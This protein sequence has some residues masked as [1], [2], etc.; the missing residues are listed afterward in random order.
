MTITEPPLTII[1]KFNRGEVDK[2]VL[3]RDDVEQINNSAGLVENWLPLRLGGMTL[4]PGIEDLEALGGDGILIPFVFAIDDTA[5]IEVT[6]NTLRFWINDAPIERS[7]VTASVPAFGGSWTDSSGSGSSVTVASSA[8]LRGA[9]TTEAI[10]RTSVTINETGTEHGLRIVVGRGP[11][12]VQ[13]GD[14]GSGSSNIYDGILGTGTHSLAVTPTADLAITFR[15]DNN[16]TV[17]VTSVAFESAGALEVPGTI[18][19][20]SSVRWHQAADIVYCAQDGP[21]FK[22][23]RRG[24]RSWSWVKYQPDDGPF[25]FINTSQITMSANALDGDPL[26]T[27]SADYF[28]DDMVGS[29]LKL[30]SNSQAVDATVTTSGNASEPIRVT[31]V[32]SAR[33]FQVNVLGN[34]SGA[35]IELQRSADESSWATVESYTETTSK[36]FDDGLDNSVLYYRLNVSAISSGAAILGLSYSA[37]SIEGIGR[38]VAVNSPTEVRVTALQQFGSTDATQDWNRSVWSAEDGYPSSVKLDEG[39]LCFAGKGRF[40]ASQSS[41]Y[42]SF[43]RSTEGAGRSILRTIGFGPVD[44]IHWMESGVRLAIGLTSDEISVRSSSFGEILTQDNAVLRPGTMEGVAPVP[45]AVMNNNIYFADRSEIKLI[46]MAYNASNDSYTSS[47][48]T[49]LA[50]EICAAGIRRVVMLKKP[51]PRIIVLLNDGSAR[52][53]LID[54]NENVL[55]WSRRTFP[56]NCTDIVVLPETGEDRAYFVLNVDGTYRLQKMA[57]IREAEQYPVDMFKRSV[58]GLSHLN[59]QTVDVWVDGGRVSEDETVS[60]GAVGAQSGAT[61]IVG[62][63]IVA[64]W[65]SGKLGQYVDRS[66]L[67]ERKNIIQIGLIGQN[68]WHA[69][70]KYGRSEDLLYNLPLY[71]N[72]SA[73]DTSALI[74]YDTSPVEFEGE[75]NTDSRIWL[76]ANAPATI[77]NIGFTI[78]KIAYSSGE[79]R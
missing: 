48:L 6:T 39:R 73:L 22:I 51:E 50:Q 3:A 1:N 8:S 35:T 25:G 41:L 10:Y 18:S 7:A 46:E 58:T 31:G 32:E 4:A 26:I 19:D 40:L 13:L 42:E 49:Y 71:Y 21:Q 20:P 37:G 28:T 64:R 44:K 36:T 65:K 57:K 14:T 76:T 43:D 68:I 74:D 47:D 63:K 29:L 72:G 34:F 30:A 56:Y 16:Y 55:A 15:N 11:V 12:R 79:G 33:A 75:H 45:P 17:I 62:K 53:L 77:L 59:G 60:G 5:L 2:T 61:I 23:E 9:D 70:F 24:A 78:D 66:V 69:G 38:I 52:I 67:N 54:R 27:A